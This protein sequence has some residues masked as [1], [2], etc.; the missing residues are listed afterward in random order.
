MD[1]HVTPL[2]GLKG[3]EFVEIPGEDEPG[4]IVTVEVQGGLPF[5]LHMRASEWRWLAI[6]LN[7]KKIAEDQRMGVP[8]TV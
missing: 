7:K 3:I 2:F 5:R 4:A 6:D 8:D 1:W